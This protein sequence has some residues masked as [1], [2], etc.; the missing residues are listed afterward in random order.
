MP[1]Q[2]DDTFLFLNSVQGSI[3]FVLGYALWVTLLLPGSWASMFAG[4]IY[5]TWQGSL[6]VF[7]GACIGAE[8]AFFL[9]RSLFRESIKNRLSKNTKLNSVINSVTKE[10]LKLVLMTRLSPI[11]P[12]GLLNLSYGLSEVS[13]R[14]YSVGLIGILPGTILYCGFG[15]LAG[16][17]SSFG[18]VMSQQMNGGAFAIRIVGLIAT[19]SVVWIITLSARRALQSSDPSA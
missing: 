1:F 7:I 8:F 19:L 10:G 12:F 17:I 15:T 6:L 2:I 13:F 18:E 16:S 9:A 3:V 11:F 14:D 4:F 5:G